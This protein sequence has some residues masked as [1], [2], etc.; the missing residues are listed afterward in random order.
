MSQKNC[1]CYEPDDVSKNVPNPV[2]LQPVELP[3]VART[4]LTNI[5]IPIPNDNL[6]LRTLFTGKIYEYVKA[7]NLYKVDTSKKTGFDTR[8]IIPDQPLRNLFSLN[9]HDTLDFSS[10]STGLH[11]IYS[12]HIN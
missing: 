8:V 10:I 3:L 4:F 6:M 2:I 5:G 7:K 12:N 9:D 1:H 11:N